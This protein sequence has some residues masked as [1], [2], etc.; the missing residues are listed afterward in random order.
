VTK[1]RRVDIKRVTDNLNKTKQEIDHLK[2]KLDRKE[3][4]RRHRL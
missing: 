2:S 1:Q 3:H 4:E